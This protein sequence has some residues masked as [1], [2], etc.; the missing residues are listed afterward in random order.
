MKK[1]IL[2]FLDKEITIQKLSLSLNTN[3][4]YLSRVIN[5]SK[6]KTFVNYI[7]DL[8][9]DFAST[10]LQTQPKLRNY[11]I[12]ALANEFGFNSAVSFSTAFNKVYKIKPT[13]FIKEL[14]T[15]NE[16]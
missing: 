14:E 15:L 4:K 5:E 12:Q 13:Y 1:T 6:G 10:Q 8:R 3:T 7:N 16:Y 11:T 2:T 9:V